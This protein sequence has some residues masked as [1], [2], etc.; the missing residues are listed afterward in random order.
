MT[1]IFSRT[2]SITVSKIQ[3]I[4]ICFLR[5]YTSQVNQPNDA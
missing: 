3:Y 1:F 4:Y 2:R 5:E